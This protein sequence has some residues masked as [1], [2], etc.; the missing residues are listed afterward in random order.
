ML[1][2][3]ILAHMGGGYSTLCVCYHKMAVNS[4]IS[5]SK[6]ASAHKLCNLRQT[7]V[8]YKTGKF[9]QANTAYMANNIGLTVQIVHERLLNQANGTRCEISQKLRLFS[10]IGH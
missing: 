3:I 1:R 7:V 8:L 6:Q 10:A 2:I 5:K 9:L 4:I